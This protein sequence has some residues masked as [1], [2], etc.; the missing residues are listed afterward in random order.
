MR[1][2]A[3]SPRRALAVLAFVAALSHV[4]RVD[5]ADASIA[6]FPIAFAVMQEDGEPVREDAWIDAELAEAE[7]LFAPHGVHFAKASRR[8]AGSVYARLETRADRDGLAAMMRP[9]VIN[10]FV[11]R[12]LKD[13]DEKERWRMGVHWRPSQ[14]PGERFIILAANAAPSVLAHELGHF[15]GNPHSPTPDNVMSYTRT[16]GE[17]FFDAPQIARIRATARRCLQTRELL[18]LSPSR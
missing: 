5:A 3:I 9:S 14:R 8:L 18:P 7:R 16:G 10:V 4:A 6:T 11:V 1:T 12:S 17:L 13:V 2:R 15:F